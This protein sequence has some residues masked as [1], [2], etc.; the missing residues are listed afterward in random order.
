MKNTSNYENL[1]FIKKN[2]KM[3]VTIKRDYRKQ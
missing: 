3:A 1:V 2:K